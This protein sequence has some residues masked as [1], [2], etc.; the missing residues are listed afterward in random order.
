MGFKKKL[1]FLT[2]LA[3]TF[4][5]VCRPIASSNEY[6]KVEKNLLTEVKRAINVSNEEDINNPDFIFDN[7]INEYKKQFAEYINITGLN[8]SEKDEIELP[9]FNLSY[10]A[11]NYSD[12]MLGYQTKLE[13]SL[14][15]EDLVKYEEL[16][17]Q[18]FNFDRYV[19]LNC[20]KYENLTPTLKYSHN[21]CPIQPINPVTPL[22]P[23]INVGD[24]STRAVVAG[25]SAI[26]SILTMAGLGQT[27]ITA[28]TA[29]ISTITAGLSTSWIPFIGWI[30]AIAIVTGALIAL[31]VII[32][33]NWEAICDAMEQIKSWFL[34]QFASFA[35]LI[36]SFFADA[37]AKGIESTIAGRDHIGNKELVWKSK[38][39]EKE[40]AIALTESLRRDKKRIF[41]MKNVRKKVNP[42]D[43]GMYVNYWTTDGYYDEDF[44]TS[45]NLYDY[46][47]STYTWYNDNARR[48][49]LN[50]STKIQYNPT[51]YTIMYHN[52]L[53]NDTALNG[54]NHYH[55]YGVKL[56]SETN[57]KEYNDLHGDLLH[58]AHSFF[59][60]MYLKSIDGQIETQTFPKNP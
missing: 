59:G 21:I 60:L 56:N 32:V 26:V 1:L 11:P 19:A 54:W 8:V 9:N 43:N 13:N 27:A 50:G 17:H 36:T 22:N 14:S 55:I 20:V 44:V 46:G 35:A 39:V 47:I 10:I 31:V 58:K 52:F 38:T 25:T 23:A 5:T 40:S 2:C 48:L 41:L 24:V 57:Q 15:T 34:E 49:M 33:Q 3:F 18:D 45:F 51:E 6:E 29:C 4:I 28:F 53:I 7:S 42:I 37:I 12:V 30:L 16:R